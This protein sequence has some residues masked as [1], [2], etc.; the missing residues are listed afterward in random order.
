MIEGLNS[1]AEAMEVFHR[2]LRANQELAIASE[3][4]RHAGRRCDLFV[5]SPRRRLQ[6]FM[7]KA[8]ILPYDAPTARHLRKS[9]STN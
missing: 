8:K 4:D 6:F 5:A 3:I 9:G 1:A 2:E 7:P